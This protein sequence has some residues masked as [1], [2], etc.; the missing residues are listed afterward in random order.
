MVLLGNKCDLDDTDI[1]H[2]QLDIYCL[3]NG[4]VG[5]FDVSAKANIDI[6]KAARFLVERILENKDIFRAKKAVQVR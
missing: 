1:D 6:D 4:F 3:K 2:N 5:S